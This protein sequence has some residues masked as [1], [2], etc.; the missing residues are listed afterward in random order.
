MVPFLA[1]GLPLMDTILAL[2]RRALSNLHVT[3]SR[4]TEEGYE[5]AWTGRVGLFTADRE[6]IHHKMLDR[7]L[8]H[9]TA[10]LIL[11]SIC[12]ALG[13]LGFGS[14]LLARTPL[15]LI[16]GSVALAT[17]I[18]LRRLGYPET[19]V[20]GRGLLLPLLDGSGN[21]FLLPVLAD[22]AFVGLA[23][24]AA[25]WVCVDPRNWQQQ[26]EVLMQ[27]AP[28]DLIVTLAVFSL[29]G[30]YRGDYRHPGLTDVL[31]L[32]RAVAVATVAVWAGRWAF[33]LAA[34]KDLPTMVLNFYLLGT[35]AIGARL[36]FRVVENFYLAEPGGRAPALIY[37]AG[38]AGAVAVREILG[39]VPL[40]LHPIGFVDDN[41]RLAGAYLDGL[42]V[43]GPASDLPRLIGDLGV[44]AVII[45][46]T[47][48]PPERIDAVR[49]LCATLSVRLSRFSVSV[50]ALA[51]QSV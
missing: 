11:Y 49:S 41:P 12:V 29:S 13:A 28:I 42:P 19:R 1:L 30:M 23:Y 44:G 4:A 22:L 35:L 33:D 38:R 43:Y 26:R 16:V 24:Y 47:D 7:G 15:V 9:R 25:H 14:L 34:R 51:D 32:V 2:V 31:R 27:T 17:F 18:A 3:R 20:L 8:S 36:S 45:A 21:R 39:N 48:I 40:G 37:G 50:E 5:F 10:V 6:H 46:S